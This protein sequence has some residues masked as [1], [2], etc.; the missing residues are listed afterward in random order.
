MICIDPRGPGKEHIIP[1]LGHI[2]P[3]ADEGIM[4]LQPFIAPSVHLALPHGKAAGADEPGPACVLT[5]IAGKNP[6]QQVRSVAL[7]HLIHAPA[8]ELGA[9][10]AIGIPGPVAVFAPAVIPFPVAYFLPG[11]LQ[12]PPDV[13][14]HGTNGLDHGFLRRRGGKEQKQSAAKGG[15]PFQ[16]SHQS[17]IPPC[18]KKNRRRRGHPPTGECF[19]RRFWTEKRKT[20]GAPAPHRRPAPGP[21]SGKPRRQRCRCRS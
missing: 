16:S 3:G 5:G 15:Y 9:P 10:L 4:P 13:V 6:V 14:R 20:R 19:P 8:E 2:I 18:R 11:H 7:I 12:Q 1:G 21:G 17:I